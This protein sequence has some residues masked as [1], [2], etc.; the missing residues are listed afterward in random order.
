MRLRSIYVF[1]CV[2]GHRYEVESD[3][4]F[5]CQCGRRSEIAWGAESKTLPPTA[6]HL[7]PHPVSKE[8]DHERTTV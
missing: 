8:S 7:P 6:G 3:A 2:C 4:P 1:T 5:V